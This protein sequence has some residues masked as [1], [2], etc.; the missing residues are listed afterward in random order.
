MNSSYNILVVD[1]EVSIADLVAELLRAQGYRAR[2]CYSGNEALKLFKSDKFDLII[3]DIMMPDIDGFSVCRK[4]RL[5]SE[6]PIIFLSAR[7]E[8]SDQVIGLM[9]GA[10][11]YIR[12]PF[13]PRELVARV[14]ARLRRAQSPSAP[15]AG[16]V[17][18]NGI[19]V[20]KKE[21]TATLHLQDLKLTPK[22]FD[23]LALLVEHQ[24][25]P[26][27]IHDIYEAIW[28][29]PYIS[30]ANNSVMVH[31]RHLR[32]KL[33]AIDSSQEFIA[34]VWGVGYKINGTP[35][36]GDAHEVEE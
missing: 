24:G 30:S 14:G 7:G 12:K 36:K 20:N 31:I 25:E 1:D 23:L 2:A 16:E 10:D 4:I 26:I 17:E 35:G 29:E 5:G 3:L 33:A 19:V 11:D 32:K 9:L 15:S 21:H 27:S 8:E 34:T 13:R 6:V 18:A 28:K 22:E